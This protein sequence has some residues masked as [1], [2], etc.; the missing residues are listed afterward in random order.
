[1]Y[2]LLCCLLGA[3]QAVRVQVCVRPEAAA[4]LHS[5][6]VKSPGGGQRSQGAAESAREH[7]AR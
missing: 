7:P 1:M 5:G 4:G 3:W 6:R 2:V